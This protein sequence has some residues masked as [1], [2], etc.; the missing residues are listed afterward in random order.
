MADQGT[1]VVLAVDRLSNAATSELS[2]S[3][4]IDV[5]RFDTMVCTKTLR[6]ISTIG[7]TLAS[8][9][10]LYKQL[11][12]RLGWLYVADLGFAKLCVPCREGLKEEIGREVR[13]LLPSFTTRASSSSCQ[14]LLT[15]GRRPVPVDVLE[16][17][18]LQVSIHSV[19]L[20][21]YGQKHLVKHMPEQVLVGSNHDDFGEYDVAVTIPHHRILLLDLSD[22]NKKRGRSDDQKFKVLAKYPLHP[23]LFGS[24]ETE[25][26]FYA[27]GVTIGL[28][29]TSTSSLSRLALTKIKF[30]S[31]FKH[32]IDGLTQ[33][34]FSV[35]SSFDAAHSKVAALRD[36]VAYVDDL[37]QDDS[38]QLG[39]IR[40]EATIRARCLKDAVNFFKETCPTVTAA[41]DYI[42]F[43]PP[44][45]LSLNM[46]WWALH[47]TFALNV[48]SSLILKTQ[49]S[50]KKLDRAQAQVHS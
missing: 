14:H 46:K 18:L 48:Y 41:M 2:T 33:V 3:T 23:A 19:R 24:K 15:H 13:K 40:M 21:A 30:Y 10:L 29:D 45:L 43:K 26:P 6:L 31:N 20:I 4:E 47:V 37:R 9:P 38:M 35:P 36:L 8:S 28:V 22:A 5:D 50:G 11:G 44:K 17:A 34:E 32:S 16:K 12:D 39:G 25:K 1:N 7:Y 49:S 27:G 42:N